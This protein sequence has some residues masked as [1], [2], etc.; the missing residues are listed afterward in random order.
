MRILGPNSSN[1]PSR[2]SVRCTARE[3]TTTMAM[4]GHSSELP[5]ADTTATDPDRAR[6][7][8]LGYKQELK[9]ALSLSVQQINVDSVLSNFALSF[10][11]VSV[12]MGVTITYNTGLRY[13]G[14]VSMTLGW[15]VVAFFNGC[16]ALS[17]AEICSSYPTSGGL[18]YWSAKLAGKEWAPLASWVTGCIDFAL[19]QLIQVIVLLGTGGL[20]G[21]G[22]MASKYVVLAIYAGILV[23][24]GLINSLR[25]Q[26][27]AWFG[28]LGAFW[29]AAVQTEET[30]KADWSG[31]MGLITAVG[32]SSVFGWI[33]LVALTSIMTDIPYLLDPGNDSGGYAVAQALYDAFHQRYGSGV[34]GLVCLGVV[35]VTTFLCGAAC[36]TSNS[37][38]AYAFSRDGALPFS[39]FW[40]RVNKH[41]VPF[42]V[43]W[44]SVTV[45]FV[46]ALTSLGSLV[47]FQA[48]LSIATIG[49]Y[50]A[51]G[52]PIFFRVT[53]ARKSFVPGPFHLG[54]YG[55]VVGWVAVAWVSLITVLFSLPVAYPVVADNF[56]YAPVLVGG[57]LFLSVGAWVLHARFWFKGPIANTGVRSSLVGDDYFDGVPVELGG[58]A[59]GVWTKLYQVEAARSIREETS[60]DPLARGELLDRGVYA[61]ARAF[62]LRGAPT[63]RISGKLGIVLRRASAP[64]MATFFSDEMDGGAGG[65][66]HVE[67]TWRR[68]RVPDH[69]LGARRR[70]TDVGSRDDDSGAGGSR[71][72][73]APRAARV[74]V[75]HVREG[76]AVR[77]RWRRYGLANVAVREQCGGSDMGAYVFVLSIGTW[78]RLHARRFW[79]KGPVINVDARPERRTTMAISRRSPE[80]P[81]AD[82]AMADP[83]RARLRQLG[84]KQE[85]KRG[86]SVLSN[87]ALSFSL[88]SVMMGVTITYNTGLRY[89]GPVSMTLGWLVVSVFNGCVA[90][91]M[92]E[93]CSAYPTSGGLYYWS[94]K[95]AGKE[96]A[97]LASWVTGCVD[98]ALAQLVQVIILL[99]T[100]GLNGGGYM[101]SK[102][103]VL[104]IYA[105][106]LAIH[107]LINSLPIQW[108]AWASLQ[109]IFTH[110]N[111]DNGMG[112]HDKAYI[113]IIG[114]LMS[115]YSLIGY[116]AGPMG[117]ITAVG[118]S[119]VFGWIF[120]VA[121]ASLMTDIPYL[122]D[123]GNDAGGY[124][125][126]QALYDAFHRRYGSGVGGLVCLGVI[127]VSTFLSGSACVTSNSRMGY[128]FSRDGAMPFSRFWY[129]VNKHE[130]PL[131]VVWLSVAV[132]FVMALTV[133]S[134]TVA[135]Q[136]MLSV[137]T[138]GPYIAYGL[139]IFFRVTTAR[140][141]FIP[142]PFHLGN[143]GVV[144]GW[145]AVTWVALVTVLFSL[146]VAY[147][148]AADNFNYAPVLVGGVMFLCIG[149][150]VL[151]ARFW[152]QGPITNVDL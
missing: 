14:P 78:I 3:R 57:V 130:V 60:G 143:Y 79:F 128:A 92:A 52:L 89:G 67:Q 84:Y 111:T 120:I 86:L 54:N 51:Y 147:P 56:N 73:Q 125:V 135:F 9:R 41:V 25:I 69:D 43:V 12:L 42:N 139:P 49:S 90:L 4:S 95:L 91:S 109:F 26:W 150:W 40:R 5:V 16:V 64:R 27:L 129:R 11:V 146:P 144:V 74:T 88:I 50:I 76:A 62:P 70:L 31:P 55:V 34:G 37:R 114:L 47:A 142:G 75:V 66:K 28:Y 68:Q 117:L 21:G 110:F 13:G 118:L 151:H 77:S 121:L 138:I 87:F 134:F 137:A 58:E 36:I 59:L 35:A 45:A 149:S 102:Y 119:S 7:H 152:F 112:I 17:M 48:M 61:L 71:W 100:G 94:A 29:N 65:H 115:Q 133:Y 63:T 19:A 96:W 127:S 24:H 39:R 44:L 105:A 104:A 93:I 97:P 22:Y 116:D 140:R 85:L 81:V 113:L 20:N 106:I 1:V 126:A 124:A 18:Y 53:T 46:M 122:L 103:V 38:M 123:P 99:G 101:A 30:K 8:Q 141:S 23:I 132:A 136:A 33:F 72:R 32:L 98:F 80:L 2:V 145:V 107:G 108:Q 15:L 6:L 82:T 131:N 10:S 83:D 148:V